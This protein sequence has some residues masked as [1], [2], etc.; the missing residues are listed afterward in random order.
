[1]LNI[2]SEQWQGELWAL[3]LLRNEATAIGAAPFRLRTKVERRA[4]AV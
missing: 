4:C 3:L 2:G 1:M